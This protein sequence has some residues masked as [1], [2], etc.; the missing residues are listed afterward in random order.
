MTEEE[1]DPDDDQEDQDVDL[2][3]GSGRDVAFR[4]ASGRLT[5]VDELTR[6]SRWRFHSTWVSD[7]VGAFNGIILPLGLITIAT[8]AVALQ[9]DGARIVAT[10][11][12]TGI[13]TIAVAVLLG[14]A[15]KPNISNFLSRS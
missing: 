4:N 12:V 15:F 6:E 2:I 11:C 13:V 1:H 7:S 8:L 14:K 5:R 9:I 10:A 3:M